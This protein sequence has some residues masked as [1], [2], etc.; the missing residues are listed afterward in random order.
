M[1]GCISDSIA[2][3]TCV[4]NLGYGVF[5]PRLPFGFEGNLLSKRQMGEMIPLD[6]VDG[7]VKPHLD[8]GQNRAPQYCILGRLI[9]N[10]L[11]APQGL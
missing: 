10:R 3:K 2:E 5:N 8:M 11:L 1:A 4:Y 9:K 7:P 6:P